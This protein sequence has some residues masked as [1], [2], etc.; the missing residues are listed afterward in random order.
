MGRSLLGSPEASGRVIALQRGAWLCVYDT[1]LWVCYTAGSPK[2]SGQGRAI[3]PDAASDL[4]AGVL[5]AAV[6]A[7]ATEPEATLQELERC[8]L[9]SVLS[10]YL[11]R[12]PARPTHVLHDCRIS[13]IAPSVHSLT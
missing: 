12:W 4:L 1:V 5:A 13:I 11:V 10:A 8:G 3:R 6:G 9:L 7:A 2:A